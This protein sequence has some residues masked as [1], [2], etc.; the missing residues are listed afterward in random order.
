MNMDL[1]RD[2]WQASCREQRGGKCRTEMEVSRLEWLAHT[3]ICEG[4]VV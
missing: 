2:P 4:W 3:F 1:W